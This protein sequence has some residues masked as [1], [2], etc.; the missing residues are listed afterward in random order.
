[1]R[2]VAHD[3]TERMQ[4]EKELRASEELFRQL[5]ENIREVFYL[6]D[7]QKLQLFYVS[8][9][10]EQVWGRTRQ[11]LYEAPYSFLDAIHPDDRE[12]ASRSY[13]NHEPFMHEYRIV[14]PDGGVRWILDRGFPV[15]DSEGRVYRLAGL[16]EDITARKLAEQALR[17]SQAETARVS[18]IVTMGELTASIA[19]EINQP[20]AAVATNASASL[21]W[22]AVQPPNLAEARE[23][24]TGAMQEAQRASRVIDRVRTLLKKASPEL[25]I[26][27]V[28]DVIR[29]VLSLADSE[30]TASGVAVQL[31]LAPDVAV[32]GDRVQL[33]QVVLNLIMNAMD[34]MA[35]VTDRP[36]T[37]AIKSVK[38]VE[39][40]VVEVQDSGKGLDPEQVSRIFDS[41]F[42]TKPDGIGMG[43][44]ISRSI[45]EAHGGQLI[46][47]PACPHGALF[48]VVL[49]KAA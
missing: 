4:T 18:R 32:I 45:V 26:L 6:R 12:N 22:L 20:L 11:S 2:G 43:L 23:A 16:A 41:F 46:A 42:T 40:V 47:S 24:M 5:A 28:N 31:A 30:L 38:D 49:P 25:R 15:R 44:S 7:A 36:R 29:E 13:F 48:Q 27:N 39:D 10:Y 19:H 17:E 34:A 9:A 3:I 37:L 33:Q 8:P 1:V 21:H 14:R 35:A